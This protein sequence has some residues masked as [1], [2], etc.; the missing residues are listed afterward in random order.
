MRSLTAVDTDI[1]QLATEARAAIVE[2][3]PERKNIAH[4]FI[5]T[6]APGVKPLT[7]QIVSVSAFT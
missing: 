2:L 4:H 5:V 7:S 1:N 3:G 6:F